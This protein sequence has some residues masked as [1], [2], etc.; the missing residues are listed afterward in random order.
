MNPTAAQ[1]PSAP[2]VSDSKAYALKGF[3]FTMLTMGLKQTGLDAIEAQILKE[4]DDHLELFSEPLVVDL[5]DIAARGEV[6]DLPGLFKLLRALGLSPVGVCNTNPL[7][8]ALAQE[9]GIAVLTASGARKRAEAA[10]A[11]DAAAHAPAAGNTGTHILYTPIR[12]GQRVFS[13]GDLTVVA[14]V[15]PGA[16]ALA[17]GSIHVYGPLRGRALAGVKGDTQARIFT[18][19][20]QAELVS[21]AGCFRV[22]DRDL[23]AQIQGKPA[24]VYL[25]GERLV[26][27]A[28]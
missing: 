23:G 5:Q 1:P 22:L 9:A 2:V 21:I 11:P 12:T 28:L 7:L 4:K 25:D 6:P 10:P 20:M 18:R 26:I 16:E 24:Q 17:T 14:S 8:Q 3:V 13:Q 15:N 19:C 27:E